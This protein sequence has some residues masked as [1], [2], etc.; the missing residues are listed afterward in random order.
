MVDNCY[1]KYSLYTDTLTV[2]DI[3]PWE[4]LSRLA[5]IRN[6]RVQHEIR[7]RIT[8]LPWNEFPI[9]LKSVFEK[10]PW[11]RGFRIRKMSRDDGVDFEAKYVTDTIPESPLIG[12]AKHWKAK[13]GSDTI[14]NFIGSVE[15]HPRVKR[16]FGMF[17]S[18]SGFTDDALETLEKCRFQ[19]LQFD[20]INLAT[21]MLKY[22][23][24]VRK[25]SIDGVDLQASFWEE[26]E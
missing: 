2:E 12:Q 5:E 20:A 4:K 7:E 25:F 21:L 10:V 3:P 24:G 9:F 17:V 15:I 18:T 1:V 22:G 13:A 14:R 26:L 6:D 8:E 23:I 11:V 19:I 16:A